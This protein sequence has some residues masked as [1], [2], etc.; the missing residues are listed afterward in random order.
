[1]KKCLCII[2][3]LAQLLIGCSK[4][5]KKPIIL[6]SDI[7]NGLIEYWESNADKQERRDLPLCLSLYEY[8]NV[9][10][11]GISFT[12][13]YS[14]HDIKGLFYLDTIPVFLEIEANFKNKILQNKVFEN[15]DFEKLKENQIEFIEN[16]RENVSDSF[17]PKTIL[18]ELHTDGLKRVR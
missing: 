8:D 17:D 1:M 9:N 6:N 5:V 16:N 11:V 3:L 10:R 12:Q 18:Y 2:L 15:A 7:E 13:I 14:Y 4:S